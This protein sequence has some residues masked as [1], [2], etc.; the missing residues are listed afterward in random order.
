MAFLFGGNVTKEE[1]IAAIRNCADELGRVPTVAELKA[2]RRVT[3]RTIRRFFGRYADA[4]REAGFDPHGAGYKLDLD[5]LFQDWAGVARRVGK[6]PGLVEY[7]KESRYSVGPLLTRFGGWTEVPRG[8][9]Q[10]VREK[11]LENEWGDVLKMLEAHEDRKR[12]ADKSSS[13][14]ITRCKKERPLYGA[15]LTPLGLVHAPTNEMGVVYLCGMMSGQ[16]GLV[17]TRIQ[18]EFPDCEVMQEVENGRWQRR[19]AEFEYESRNFLLHKH[20]PNECDMIICWVHNWPEC[21]EWIEVVE[22]SREMR[23]LLK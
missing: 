7:S 22:L 13:T 10:F 1:I 8:L 17:V 18:P 15:P 4:L 16:L 6:L 23:R 3:L 9:L 14:A 5:T 21:P 20:D 2:M 19:D 11:G 12:C